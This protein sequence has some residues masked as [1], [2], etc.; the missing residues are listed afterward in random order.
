MAAVPVE[1][2]LQR[3]LHSSWLER[4]G[5]G[6]QA[7]AELRWAEHLQLIGY[8]TGDPQPGEAAWALGTV[9]RWRRARMLDARGAADPE[10]CANYLAVARLWSGGEPRFAARAGTARRRAA[11]LRCESPA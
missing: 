4:T 7:E 5:A 3:L 8:P 6:R 2:A 1:D 9:L 10:L 11:E